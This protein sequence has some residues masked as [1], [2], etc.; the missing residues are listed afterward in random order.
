MGGM[1]GIDLAQDSDRWWTLVNAVMNIRV[2]KNA[3]N[4]L[5]CWEPVSFSKRT[6]FH[7]VS[8]G[9][10]CNYFFFWVTLLGSVR[11]HKC[12]CHLQRSEQNIQHRRTT[13]NQE[14]TCSMW[15]MWN[16]NSAIAISPIARHTVSANTVCNL[17]VSVVE[18]RSGQT[19]FSERPVV[20]NL[21]CR[22]HPFG[23]QNML[24]NLYRKSSKQVS[25]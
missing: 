20:R 16:S 4:F 5:T 6:L 15:F 17:V 14:W 12:D 21:Y 7:G 19:V 9:C 8:K 3:G 22:S 1:D 10:V 11:A 18:L 23:S 24:P 25:F 13:I 2:P